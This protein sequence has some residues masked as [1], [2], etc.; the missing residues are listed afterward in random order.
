MRQ[1]YGTRPQGLGKPRAG[2]DASGPSATNIGESGMARRTQEV[3]FPT[4]IQTEG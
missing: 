2:D 4:E 1:G 3:A